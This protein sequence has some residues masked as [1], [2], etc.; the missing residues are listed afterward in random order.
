[1][2]LYSGQTQ[3]STFSP[4]RRSSSF[5]DQCR[6]DRSITA[7]MEQEDDHKSS[8]Q[9]IRNPVQLVAD[10][11]KRQIRKKLETGAVAKR[12]HRRPTSTA[13]GYFG[14]HEWQ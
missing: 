13:D 9:N 1:M 11:C 7:S 12:L 2:G 3:G 4:T 8:V 14:K 10:V 5:L 6:T